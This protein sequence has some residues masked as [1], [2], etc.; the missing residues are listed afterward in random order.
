MTPTCRHCRK[1][2]VNR[3]RGLCWGCYYRPGL[4]DL[5]PSTSKY[6]RRGIGNL[7]GI[8]PMPATPTRMVPGSEAKIAILAE[9]ASRGESLH[10]P[11][12]LAV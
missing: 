5:Y 3:P 6:A 8:R 4:R 7:T 2:N 10:H 11:G 9:R 1:R 12:D